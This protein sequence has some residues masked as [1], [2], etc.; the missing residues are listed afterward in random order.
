M[1]VLK[2][3][4]RQLVEVSVIERQR[5][6]KEIAQV[7]VMAAGVVRFDLTLA[8]ALELAGA[9]RLAVD[10]A[11]ELEQRGGPELHPLGPIDGSLW[12]PRRR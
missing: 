6:E 9:L 7:R 3:L 2:M 5:G 1:N 4:D 8:E 10:Y 11:S 12:P